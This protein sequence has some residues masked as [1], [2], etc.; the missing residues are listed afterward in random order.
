MM[1]KRKK[2]YDQKEK[3]NINNNYRVDID[4]DTKFYIN[5]YTFMKYTIMNKIIKVY[6][7]I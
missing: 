3:Q 5:L 1:T 7:F 2:T 4:N 6:T